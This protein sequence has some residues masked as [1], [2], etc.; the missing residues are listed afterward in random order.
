MQAKLSDHG[1]TARGGGRELFAET[2][3]QPEGQQG[4]ERNRQFCQK[5]TGEVEHHDGD[6]IEADMEEH[7]GHQE[8][9]V[10]AQEAQ[11]NEQRCADM[12]DDCGD[13]FPRAQ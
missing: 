1:S 13:P 3:D 4:G 9:S 10:A 11:Q 12:E 5:N 2:E 6:R 7:C 8:A